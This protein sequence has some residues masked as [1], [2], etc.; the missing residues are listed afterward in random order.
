M[1]NG[2]FELGLKYDKVGLINVAAR[3]VSDSRVWSHWHC[4]AARLWSD[5]VMAES[6][7]LF[8]SPC[9][10]A[11]RTFNGVKMDKEWTG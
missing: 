1:T 8:E 4:F 7:V 10:R 11:R 3:R 6:D 5:L 9:D 2:L